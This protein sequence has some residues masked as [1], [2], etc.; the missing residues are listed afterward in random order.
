MKKQRHLIRYVITFLHHEVVRTE[1][2]VEAYDDIQALKLA[3]NKLIAQGWNEAGDYAWCST[4]GGTFRINIEGCVVHPNE[5][6]VK[7]VS[8]DLIDVSE[9]VDQMRKNIESGYDILE[10]TPIGK[11]ADKGYFWWDEDKNP[12]LDKKTVQKLIRSVKSGQPLSL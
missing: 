3:F 12:V 1:A 7:T 8:G 5:P 11:T 4:G 10:Q 9:Y 6:S 2:V